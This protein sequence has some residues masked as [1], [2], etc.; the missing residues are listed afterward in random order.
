[1]TLDM[2]SR[3]TLGVAGFFAALLSLV[4]ITPAHAADIVFTESFEECTV[5][6]GVPYDEDLPTAIGA[7]NPI[8][9]KVWAGSDPTADCPGWTATSQAFFAQWVSGGTF[10]DGT[11]AVWLNEG[12]PGGSM[13]TDITGLTAGHDYTLSLEAWTDDRNAPTSL[14]VRVTNGSDVAQKELKMRAGQGIQP[15]SH[16]F[17]AYGDTI[18]LELIGAEGTEASPVLDN[19]VITDAGLTP[20]D[21]SSGGSSG[22]NS[23]DSASLAST[24]FNAANG[25]AIV[26]LLVVAGAALLVARRATRR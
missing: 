24:G 12:P 26:G 15:L 2:G 17:S 7:D 11:A 5:P 22:G 3:V 4:S 14:F 10:P 19:I 21:G 13:A 1:M 25:L 20:A 16:T 6:G 18:T 8:H 9:V 23:N